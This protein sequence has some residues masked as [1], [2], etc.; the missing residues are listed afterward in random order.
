MNWNDFARYYDWEFEKIC[1]RQAEDIGFWLDAAARFGSP[2]LELCCGSGRITI[3]L[4][5]AGFPVTAVDY[6]SALLD[7]LQAKAGQLPISTLQAD[8]RSFSLDATFPFAFISYSS[9]QQLLTQDDQIRCLSSVHDHLQPDGIL[10]IDL[11]PCLCEGPDTFPLTLQYRSYFSPAKSTLAM[12][13]SYDIDRLNLIKHWHDRYEELLPDGSKRTFEHN[14]SLRECSLDYMKLLLDACGFSPEEV[15][16]DFQKGPV[17][18][19]S[20]NL[21]LIAQKR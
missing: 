18:P 20:H 6:S 5:K 10:G 9:F 2:I 16:G 7:A 4:A 11:T 13:T 3:P 17:V 1:T 8:M 14:I 15:Y 21:I 12:F 19:E